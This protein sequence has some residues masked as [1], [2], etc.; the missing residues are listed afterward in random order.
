MKRYEGVVHGFVSLQA[1][2][3]QGKT[4][5]RELAEELKASLRPATD[6]LSIASPAEIGNGPNLLGRP[7]P[8]D[9]LDYLASFGNFVVIRAAIVGLFSHFWHSKPCLPKSPTPSPSRSA[10]DHRSLAVG[11]FLHFS[12]MPIACPQ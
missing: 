4:A 11:L 5:T 3:D 6:T 8:L 7:G 12:H 2:I 10:Q 1:A 9:F